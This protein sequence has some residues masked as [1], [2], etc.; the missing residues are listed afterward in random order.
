MIRIPTIY[1]GTRYPCDPRPSCPKN[2]CA[3]SGASRC[4]ACSTYI[5]P[6]SLQPHSRARRRSRTHPCRRPRPSCRGRSGH[7]HET[8][9][10]QRRPEYWDIMAEQLRCVWHSGFVPTCTFRPLCGNAVYLYPRSAG[11]QRQT[12][13][14][15]LHVV[16]RNNCGNTAADGKQGARQGKS[17]ERQR[18]GK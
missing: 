12:L 11:L 17:R 16:K 4:T 7:V 8:V 1:P 2:Y 10:G 5:Q 14:E 3:V 6:C 15:T 13:V 18:T 9:P